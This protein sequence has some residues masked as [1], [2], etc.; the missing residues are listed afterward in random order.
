[1]TSGNVLDVGC[2]T[3]ATTLA[4][5]QRTRSAVGIDLSEPMVAAA[6]RRAERSGSQARF[7]CADAQAYGFEPSSFDVVISRFG[8]M[9]FADPEAAFANLRRASRKDAR[10]RLIVWR[11]A[12]ENAFMTTAERAAEPLLPNLPPRRP[13]LP[14]QFAFAD[15]GRVR[16]LL[17]RSGWQRIEIRPIDVVCAMP[18]GDLLL[19]VGRVGP[20]GLALQELDA[21]RRAVVLDAVRA[22]F[23]PFVHGSEVRFVAACWDIA[24]G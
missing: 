15:S 16:A 17:E 21:G 18:E 22:A 4:A 6:R 7:L 8:V 19:Y 2:G 11:S 20:V 14:G 5:A 24:A 13:D 1:V 12:Q 3:G 9:F 10:L 23:E